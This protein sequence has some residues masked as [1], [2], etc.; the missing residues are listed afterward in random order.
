MSLEQGDLVL[1]L[2]PSIEVHQYSGHDHDPGQFEGLIV[3]QVGTQGIPNSLEY[4]GCPVLQ[5]KT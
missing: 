2:D 4:G 3:I 5:R 1:Q